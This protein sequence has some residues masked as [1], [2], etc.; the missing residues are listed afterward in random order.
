MYKDYVLF[1]CLLEIIVSGLPNLESF[2]LYCAYTMESSK[3]AKHSSKE[4][5]H[6]S[7]DFY[8]KEV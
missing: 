1:S 2:S 4:A 5:N 7:E 6:R 8:L 3:E